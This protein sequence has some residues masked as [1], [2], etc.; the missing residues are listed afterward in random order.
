MKTSNDGLALIKASEGLRLRGYRCPAGVPTIGYG[1]TRS[2]VLPMTITRQEA[3]SLL[4]EDM[5]DFEAML[6]SRWIGR[7]PDPP[8]QH[9]YDAV[10]SFLFNLGPGSVGV[11]D[12]LFMLRSGRP[13]TLYRA[14]LAG[15]FALAAMQ[16]RAWAN[17]PLLGLRIRRERERVLFSG[18]DW[19]TVVD[20]AE[21]W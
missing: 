5:A 15:N 20:G 3:D 12:G 16:F 8:A 13:S 7:V 17:P 21:P 10:S 11:T 2:V 1:H 4:A 6:G 18:G 9:Q 14:L 19:R